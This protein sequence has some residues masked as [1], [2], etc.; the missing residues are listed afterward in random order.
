MP[1]CVAGMHR[2]GTSMLT[3][4]LH[5]AGLYFGPES[6]LS[7]RAPEKS[8]GY[9]EHSKF[10]ELNDELLIR[11]GGSWGNPPPPIA[12]DCAEQT[13]FRDLRERAEALL[14]G[15]R[16]REPWGWKDPRNSLTLPFWA[17][18]ARGLKVVICLRHPS[19]VARSLCRGKSLNYYTL[20]MTLW[21]MYPRLAVSIP[22]YQRT[23]LRHPMSL[24]LLKGIN[25]LQVRLSSRQRETYTR[26]LGFTLWKIYNERVLESTTPEQ[27]I[28]THY[29]SYF[30]DPRAELRRVLAFLHVP[31]SDESLEQC[32]SFI[33]AKLRHNRAASQRPND[34]RVS[35]EVFVLYERMCE[36]AGLILS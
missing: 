15:F 8:D 28:I 7:P 2:S 1:V 18:L 24:K 33:S 10:V 17:G 19:E 9:M 14:R 4:L 21:N 29:E 6:E 35:E 5:I 16:G 36:E 11:L 27:R 23:L 34:P 22:Q 30:L 20:N 12:F 13:E 26:L 31:A 32:V 25:Q 3:K